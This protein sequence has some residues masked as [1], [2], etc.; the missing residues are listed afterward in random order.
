MSRQA[1]SSCVVELLS[2]L[3]VVNHIN[4]NAAKYT[5]FFS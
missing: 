3:P 1:Y 4:V 5:H 2:G